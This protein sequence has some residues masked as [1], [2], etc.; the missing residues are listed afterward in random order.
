MKPLFSNSSEKASLQR[1]LKALESMLEDAILGGL[2]KHSHEDIQ[3]KFTSIGNL[4]SADSTQ[5]LESLRNSFNERD[6]TTF[7]IHSNPLF[8]KDSISSSCMNDNEGGQEVDDLPEEKDSCSNCCVLAI[9]VGIGMILM[10]F[11]MVNISGC[12]QYVEQTNFAIP[13]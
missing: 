6:S 8:E 4:V 7:T 12:F 11:I 10:G 9:G 3:Q 5:K 2:E 13:T 1:N